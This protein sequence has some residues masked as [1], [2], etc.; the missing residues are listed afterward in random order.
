MIL[1]ECSEG[2]ESLCAQKKPPEGGSWGS[3]TPSATGSLYCVQQVA[4]LKSGV[5][6]L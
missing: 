2:V 3:F 4:M 5:G 1:G 6:E